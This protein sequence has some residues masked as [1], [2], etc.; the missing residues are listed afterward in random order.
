MMVKTTQANF[1]MSDGKNWYEDLDDNVQAIVFPIQA[2]IPL[3]CF[4]SQLVV[5]MD[6]ILKRK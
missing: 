4:P 5:G 3:N 6:M 1:I 2:T